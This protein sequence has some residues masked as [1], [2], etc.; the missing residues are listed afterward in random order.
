M[1]IFWWMQLDLVSLKGSAISSG[2]FCGVCW[3]GGALGTLSTNGQS[4][5]TVL[6]S[7]T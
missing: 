6:H 2:V 1:P 4:C 3:C 5:I 7:F